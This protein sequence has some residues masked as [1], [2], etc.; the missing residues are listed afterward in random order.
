MGNV[1]I[2]LWPSLNP[3]SIATLL[4]GAWGTALWSQI[5]SIWAYLKQRH[6][7]SHLW[8]VTVWTTGA[9][10][11]TNLRVWHF[12]V[13]RDK[14][15]VHTEFYQPVLSE[16][17]MLYDMMYVETPRTLYVVRLKSPYA[18][19]CTFNSS[20]TSEGIGDILCYAQLVTTSERSMR[21]RCPVRCWWKTDDG[22]MYCVFT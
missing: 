1:H 7:A 19:F 18:P 14:A 11:W 15:F 16:H 13:P 17:M 4:V 5:H 8:L 21:K 9:K 12:T 2:L 20:A 10:W 6:G 22:I 3:Y